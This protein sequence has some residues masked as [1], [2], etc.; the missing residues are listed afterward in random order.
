MD[1]ATFSPPARSRTARRRPHRFGR[2]SLVSSS[3]TRCRRWT[4]APSPE[5][6][7]ALLQEW[8]GRIG[9]HPQQARQILSK[10]LVGRLTFTPKTENGVAFYEFTGSGALEPILAGVLPPAGS[11]GAPGVIRPLHTG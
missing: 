11:G 5:D 8:R 2:S 4:P 10:L 1:L 7:S 6:L 3:S 9:G